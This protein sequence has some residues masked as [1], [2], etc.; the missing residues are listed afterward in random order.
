[1]RRTF[2]D[3]IIHEDGFTIFDVSALAFAGKRIYPSTR[4]VS[5]VKE[6]PR[7]WHNRQGSVRK[8]GV[9]EHGLCR[10]PIIWIEGLRWSLCLK[11]TCNN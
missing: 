5:M 9:A 2:I 1:M 10:G 3:P 4:N 7:N 8:F 6:F 11:M